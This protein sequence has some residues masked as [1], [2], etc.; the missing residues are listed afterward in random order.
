MTP[1]EPPAA[2]TAAANPLCYPLRI[3]AG[4]DTAP[5]AAV[6]AAAAPEMPA[7][8]MAATTATTATMASH[9]QVLLNFE[10]P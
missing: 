6:S 4:M 7:T 9:G 3:M 8:N 1:M 5:T 2:W 10:K